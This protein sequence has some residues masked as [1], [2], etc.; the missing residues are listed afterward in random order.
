M[1]GDGPGQV[2]IG[3]LGPGD[4]F[5]P[6]RTKG[7]DGGRHRRR[8]QVNRVFMSG[9]FDRPDFLDL[10]SHS[11]CRASGPDGRYFP[12]TEVTPQSVVL[13]P[14]NQSHP[15]PGR[16]DRVVDGRCLGHPGLP[17]WNQG[18]TVQ[19]TGQAPV[20]PERADSGERNGPPPWCPD[21]GPSGDQGL[22]NNDS[23]KAPVVLRE[24]A[25]GGDAAGGAPEVRRKQKEVGGADQV[26]LGRNGDSG[27]AYERRRGPAKGRAWPRRRRRVRVAAAGGRGRRQPTGR[28]AAVAARCA[29]N[30]HSPSSLMIGSGDFVC[31]EGAI[32]IGW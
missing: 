2:P 32:C 21:R 11:R 15:A 30:G 4:G 12:P 5:R 29:R 20:P 25:N 27:P 18:A 22:R 28:H 3:K 8:R 19:D 10:E 6:F 26:G 17:S 13:Q 7:D 9:R 1:V 14:V 16:Q 31:M 24:P 23:D